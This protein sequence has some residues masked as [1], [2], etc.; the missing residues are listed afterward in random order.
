MTELRNDVCEA[1]TLT[2][3][4]EVQAREINNGEWFRQWSE[5]LLQVHR[6][7]IDPSM[8]KRVMKTLADSAGSYDGHARQIS[9]KR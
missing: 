7:K 5:R 1:E 2:S 6:H 3:E 8:R 9:A 4:I